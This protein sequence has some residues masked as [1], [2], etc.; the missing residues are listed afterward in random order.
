MNSKQCADGS[1]WSE[2]KKQTNAIHFGY[3][4]R[5]EARK[6]IYFKNTNPYKMTAAQ[7]EKPLGYNCSFISVVGSSGSI[8]DPSILKVRHVKTKALI[9][10]HLISKIWGE[11][12]LDHIEYY[13]PQDKGDKSDPIIFRKY[14]A[15]MTAKA[16]KYARYQ[17]FHAISRE[18]NPTRVHFMYFPHHKVEATQVLNGLP[19]IISEEILISPNYFITISVIERSAMG[20]WDK[21]KRAFTEPN[22]MH[23]EEAMEYMFKGTGLTALYLDQDPQA[24]LKNKMGN[25]D[26][27]YLQKAYT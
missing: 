27:A 14:L 6:L 20:I 22:E 25:F 10:Y 1:K 19:C 2:H 3:K 17:L 4:R 8:I 26:E 7:A 23:N 9:T 24:A 5:D 13:L 12:Y 15:N 16:E 18:K 11:I 21:D